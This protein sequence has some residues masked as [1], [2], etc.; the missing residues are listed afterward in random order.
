[1]ASYQ[2]PL[3]AFF[4]TLCRSQVKTGSCMRHSLNSQRSIMPPATIYFD[5][6]FASVITETNQRYCTSGSSARSISLRSMDWMPART[7]VGIGPSNIGLVNPVSLS[8]NMTRYVV[9][10]EIN[11]FKTGVF[12]KVNPTWSGT[13][14]S[15]TGSFPSI[16]RNPP[17]TR[18]RGISFWGGVYTGSDTS[19]AGFDRATLG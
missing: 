12:L 15:M 4:P 8:V 18:A 1:M 14:A 9:G 5:G 17:T 3:V 7:G 16:P 11:Q 6:D 10:F 2:K 19:S 13:M